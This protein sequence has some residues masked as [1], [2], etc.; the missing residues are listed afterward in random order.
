MDFSGAPG[1]H[2]GFLFAVTLGSKFLKVYH[3]YFHIHMTPVG[4]T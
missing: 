3:G 4:P 2:F 1:G